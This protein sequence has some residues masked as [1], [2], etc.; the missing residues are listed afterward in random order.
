MRDAAFYICITVLIVLF[1]GEPDLMDGMRQWLF[2]DAAA[3]CRSTT[4]A[5]S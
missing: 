2:M 5:G 4:E 1:A 3:S